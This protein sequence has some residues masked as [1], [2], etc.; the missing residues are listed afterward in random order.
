MDSGVTLRWRDLAAGAAWVIV[1]V[2]AVLDSL[3]GRVS[4]L[5]FWAVLLSGPA[6]VL[7]LLAWHSKRDCY[8]RGVNDGLE[9]GG[10]VRL[11]DHERV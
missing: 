6:A 8:Q 7:S 5:G 11:K 9:M 4:I 3:D 1:A 2:L 10:V